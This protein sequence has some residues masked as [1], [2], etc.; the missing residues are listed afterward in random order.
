AKDVGYK[1]IPTVFA[2]MSDEQMRISTLRHNRARGTEDVELTSMLLR[3]MEKLGA[4]E[5]AKEALQLSDLDMEFLLGD[6]NAPDALAGEEFSQ[7]WEAVGVNEMA[8]DIDKR[9]EEGQSHTIM[10]THGSPI[11]RSYSKKAAQVMLE[12]DKKLGEAKTAEERKKLKREYSVYRVAFNFTSD[13]GRM[14]NKV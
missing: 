10:S 1:E 3:D 8:E 11:V 14:V 9:T 2:Q 5:Y 4:R 13:E 7:A 12:L 6:T